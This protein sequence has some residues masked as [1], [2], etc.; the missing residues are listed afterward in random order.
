AL[1]GAALRA[2][3]V[4]IGDSTSPDATDVAEAVAA[5]R[6]AILDLGK[7]EMG[8]KTLVDALAPFAAALSTGVAAELALA[9]AWTAAAAVATAQAKATSD[10]LPRMGRARPHM[11]KSLGTPDPGAISLALAVTAVAA[12]LAD[13]T[14]NK[15]N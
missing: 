9:D 2:A 14:T 7:A 6:D 1:W 11:E 13:V 4:R 12:V 8:D 5:G 10:L 3:G 15:E